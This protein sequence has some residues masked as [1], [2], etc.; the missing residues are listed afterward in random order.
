MDQ[1]LRDTRP[2]DPIL[3]FT[4]LGEGVD[5][6]SI[7]GY[8]E[9]SLVGALQIPPGMKISKENDRWKWIGNGRK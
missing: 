6:R 9:K 1:A 3:H 5:K 8:Y 7:D 2:P 4:R